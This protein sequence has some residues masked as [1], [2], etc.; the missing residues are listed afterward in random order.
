MGRIPNLCG[1]AIPLCDFA[2]YDG[3][4]HRLEL[5]LFHEAPNR[6]KRREAAACVLLDDSKCFWKV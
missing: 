3:G 5:R 1:A 6:G 4:F 2:G